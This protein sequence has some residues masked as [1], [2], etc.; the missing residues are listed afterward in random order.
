MTAM[1][2]RARIVFD[3]PMRSAP[4]NLGWLLPLALACGENGGASGDGGTDAGGTDAGG[5]GGG[6]SDSATGGGGTD[7]GG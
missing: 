5:T 1:D 4:R 3:R 7:G 2:S 6:G